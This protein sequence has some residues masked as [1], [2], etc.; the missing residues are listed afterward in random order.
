MERWDGGTKLARLFVTGL[1]DDAG[2]DDVVPMVLLLCCGC[3]S[4]LDRAT[5]DPLL[6]FS[7][8]DFEVVL[9]LDL[10]LRSEIGDDQCFGDRFDR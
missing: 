6:V 5:T 8:L 2:D 10:L 9:P 1:G 3:L 7:W 4:C